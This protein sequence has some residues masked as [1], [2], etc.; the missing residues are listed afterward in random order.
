MK[1][2]IFYSKIE[3]Q[4]KAEGNVKIKD[5]NNDIEIFTNSIVYKKNDE[6]IITNGKSK[7]IYDKNKIITSKNFKFERNKNILNASRDVKIHDK[8]EDYVIYTRMLPT[9]KT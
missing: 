7:A 8:I 6:I 2:K 5:I 1:L 4:L 3:N 9:I